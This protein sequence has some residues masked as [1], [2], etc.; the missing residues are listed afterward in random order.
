MPLIYYGFKIRDFCGS[1]DTNLTHPS[2]PLQNKKGSDLSQKLSYVHTGPLVETVL[3]P[4]PS[5]S[6]GCRLKA[7]LYLRS[8]RSTM[9]AFIVLAASLWRLHMP[10]FPV[11]ELEI[12][13]RLS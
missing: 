1:I 11:I 13:G 9:S 7:S 2:A 3:T 10:Q 12:D 4:D 6:N 8:F 5:P